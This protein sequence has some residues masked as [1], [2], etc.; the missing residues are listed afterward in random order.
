MMRDLRGSGHGLTEVP[1]WN[2]PEGNVENHKDL[3]QD[4]R[5]SRED[6]N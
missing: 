1:F 5:Y 2:L 6:L 3:S 4:S